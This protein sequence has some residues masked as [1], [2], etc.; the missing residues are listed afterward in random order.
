MVTQNTLRMIAGQYVFSEE[1]IRSV[2]LLDLNRFLKQ[3]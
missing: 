1:T 2:T 3:I